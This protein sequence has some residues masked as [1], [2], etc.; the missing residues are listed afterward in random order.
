MEE[1]EIIEKLNKSL[2]EIE[3]IKD[4]KRCIASPA[5]KNWKKN[6]ENALEAAGTHCA[7]NLQSFRLLKFGA[8]SKAV[9]LRKNLEDFVNYNNYLIELE[10]AKKI[11]ESS[12]KTL[13]LFGKKERELPF[14][15]KKKEAPIAA[16]EIIIGNNKVSI[17][18]I[19]MIEVFWCFQQ[20]ID[21][22]KGIPEEIKEAISK[23]ISNWS[24]NPLLS[25]TFST[26]LDKV[27][28][29]LQKE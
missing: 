2:E 11:I 17:N 23:T 16:G 13:K 21:Q 29:L 3:T 18:T 10:A 8:P 15:W 25:S 19:S 24:N 12:I 4:D 28:G 22:Q 14:D 9:P 20:L 26:S 5:V 6:I 27:L 7:K 1:H